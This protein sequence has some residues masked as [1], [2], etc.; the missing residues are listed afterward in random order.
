MLL[1]RI[2]T[3]LVLLPLVL[4]AVWW[5]PPA[6]LYAIFALAGL[7]AAWEWTA[8]MGLSQPP[9]NGLRGVYVAGSVLVLAG[10]WLVQ[11][12]W[13]WLAAAASL[14]W[15]V[16]L[17]LLPGFP[18]NLAR[19]RPGTGLLGVLG[20]LLWVPAVTSLCTLRELPSAA[21]GLLYVFVLVWAADIGAY[22]AGR[23]LGRHKLAPQVSPGKTVEGA[24][25]GLL[26]CMVWAGL[27]IGP[28]FA[29]A[30]AADWAKL[31]ALSL[32]AALLSIVGDLSISMFKRLSGVKD[33]GRLLPGHGGILDRID[34]LL[35][36]A[37]VM[38][39]GLYWLQR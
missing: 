1:Q 23:A 30:G 38:A 27:A 16:A 20:Q 15:L 31:L 21:P 19:H 34:S 6:G 10:A 2:I 4:A 9:R 35:A 22:F 37:P 26:L 29:P 25:G 14:W 13:R 39:L 33:S 32:V 18:G 3:A 8:L 11:A 7:L 17:C 24:M 36:A 5:A 12:Q 28:V